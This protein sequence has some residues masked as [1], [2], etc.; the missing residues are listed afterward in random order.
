MLYV[1]GSDL[2]KIEKAAACGSDCVCLD[3]ED[4][5]AESM[6]TE[7]RGI[8][9]AALRNINF[10][11]SERMVR[12]NPL[13]SAR[14]LD[15]LAAVLPAHPDAIHLPKVFDPDQIAAIDSLLHKAEAANGWAENSIALVVN[16]ESA[17]GIVN[18][19]SICHEC[20]VTP[21]F[22]GVVFGAEDFTADVGATRSPEAY[23]LLYARSAVVTHCVAFGLQAI[24]M[25]TVNFK[26]SEVL[27]RESLQGARLGFTGKQV[28]HPAQVEPV[29]RIFTPSVEEVEWARQILSL[30][31]Q[32]AVDGQGAFAHGGE[33]VDRPVIKRAELILTRAGVESK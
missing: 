33:M 3:L 12:V 9:A 29:Q 30:A 32:F 14:A 21:R 19:E 2:H 27:E 18:I 28:I 7:A 20:E 4:G 6:K 5:V 1:P 13:A 26:D 17:R 10:G 15:D 25:V 23:E 22:Q 16:V 31:Q 11:R 24:D 8:I